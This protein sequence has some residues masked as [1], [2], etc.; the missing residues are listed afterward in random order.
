MIQL[1]F[2]P[3]QATAK[4]LNDP[5]FRH[6]IFSPRDLC[7]LAECLMPCQS[8]S[9][10]SPCL[11]S[12]AIIHE[13]GIKQRDNQLL[14]CPKRRAMHLRYPFLLYFLAFVASS[15]STTLVYSSAIEGTSSSLLM[16]STIFLRDLSAS[17]LVWA[18]RQR[19]L[20][21]P[22]PHRICS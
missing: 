17:P 20:G 5:P 16:A 19:A 12:N 13:T 14:C 18:T 8:P 9:L 4:Y 21:L 6:V 22:D 10:F 2:L 3:A 1:S 11:A 7:V 15:L